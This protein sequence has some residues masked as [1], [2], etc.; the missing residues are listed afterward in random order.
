MSAINGNFRDFDKLPLRSAREGENILDGEEVD[1]EHGCE[2]ELTPTISGLLE[3]LDK[4]DKLEKLDKVEDTGREHEAAEGES[5]E[6]SE[7]YFELVLESEETESGERKG[8]EEEDDD[9]EV[10]DD[11]DDEGDD[12]FVDECPIILDSE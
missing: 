12:K 7:K 2:A 6:D 9:D 4:R 5:R 11:K 8:G 1:L 3:V 10:N